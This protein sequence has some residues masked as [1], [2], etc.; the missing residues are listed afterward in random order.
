MGGSVNTYR[1]P[2]EVVDFAQP[3]FDP[4]KMEWIK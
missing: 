2:Q 1:A 3:P 4:H